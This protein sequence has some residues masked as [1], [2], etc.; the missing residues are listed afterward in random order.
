MCNCTQSFTPY[1]VLGIRE[2]TGETTE[3]FEIAKMELFRESSYI[4]GDNDIRLL[5]YSFNTGRA[6]CMQTRSWRRQRE[7]WCSI[8]GTSHP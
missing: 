4:F 5:K 6:V 7:D 8:S 1:V 3:K 2:F